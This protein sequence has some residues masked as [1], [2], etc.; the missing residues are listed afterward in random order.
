[1]VAGQKLR[2]FVILCHL[3]AAAIV[4]LAPT[5]THAQQLPYGSIRILVGFAPGGTTD[6]AARLIAAE[7]SEASGRTIIVENKPGASGRIVAEALKNAT[8]DGTTL[9]L[10]P[11]VV[12]VIAPLVWKDL[13]Y[14]PAKDFAPITHVA[15]YQYAFFVGLDHPARTMQELVAWMKAHP[16][17]ANFGTPGAGSLPH[18]LGMMIGKAAGIDMVHVAYKGIAPLATDLMGGRIPAAVDAL[19]DVLELHRAGNLRI[20]ATS[21]AKRS[22]LLPNVPT[23]K[24]Q[25]FPAI[26]ASGWIAM[27]APAKTPKPV[28][29]QWSGAIVRALQTPA[30]RQRL[31][32]LGYEPTGTTPEE[33]AAIMA[34]DTARWAPIIK[35]SRF[36]AD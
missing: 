7:I 21:G 2:P 13:S 23:F 15:G 28:I 18:F 17:Q 24:E 4:V 5:N 32:E 30:I 14:D 29:D 25:G 31:I 6:I 20:I 33:L 3:I 10:V 19:S 1:M 34:A 36:S 35:A 9:M 26:E 16:K 22:P 8:P 27:Y 12:P 11:I